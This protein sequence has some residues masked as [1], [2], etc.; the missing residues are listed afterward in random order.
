[1]SEWLNKVL[2][3][4]GEE[5]PNCKVWRRLCDGYFIEKCPICG[6]D[7]IYIFDVEEKEV[8]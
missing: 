8:P 7:E 2:D 4:S 3:D 6:D 5:C 1:M